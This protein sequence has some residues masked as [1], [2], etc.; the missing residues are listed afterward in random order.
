M[1]AEKFIIFIENE[2]KD[3][4][5]LLAKNGDKKYI[6]L[7]SKE[8]KYSDVIKALETKEGELYDFI[9][10]NYMKL[11]TELENKKYKPLF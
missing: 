6:T 9:F 2:I 8:F 11:N 10:K 4:K 3:F 5:L 1:D 7:N